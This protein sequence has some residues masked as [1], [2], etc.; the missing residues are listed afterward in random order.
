MCV[1]VCVGG[2]VCRSAEQIRN[3]TSRSLNRAVLSVFTEG[4]TFLRMKGTA[5]PAQV[6]SLSVCV[7]VRVCVCERGFVTYKNVSVS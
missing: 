1:W 4:E 2:Y 6:T 7:F 3:G 5:V